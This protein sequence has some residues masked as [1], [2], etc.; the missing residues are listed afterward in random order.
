MRYLAVAHFGR[1]R[2]EFV[3]G[4]APVHWQAAVQLALERRRASLD[5]LWAESATAS[6]AAVAARLLPLLTQSAVT[7]V[8]HWKFEPAP[9]DTKESI[10]IKFDP[11]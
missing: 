11:Q 8:G 3:A 9:K 10:E 4:S 2:G 5:T 6:P 1:G 7:A